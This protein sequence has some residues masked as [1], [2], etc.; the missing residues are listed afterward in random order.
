MTE[1]EKDPE[2]TLLQVRDGYLK[3]QYRRSYYNYI[4]ECLFV[5]ENKRVD[6][7]IVNQSKIPFYKSVK[8]GYRLVTNSLRKASKNIYVKG[9]YFPKDPSKSTLK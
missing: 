7:R 8:K 5:D 2:L 9:L 3:L 1:I 4:V 6:L